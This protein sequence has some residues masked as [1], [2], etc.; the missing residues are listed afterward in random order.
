MELGIFTKEGLNKTVLNSPLTAVGMHFFERHE[1]PGPH[2]IFL[3]EGPVLEGG[4]PL[5]Q[6]L[7]LRPPFGLPEGFAICSGSSTPIEIFQLIPITAHEQHLIV[8]NG[9]DKFE[10][11]VLAQ[12]ID[13]LL[14]NVRQEISF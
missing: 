5:F 7:Y 12:K 8:T 14:F 13:L 11:A 6:S 3:G 2:G 9:W 10:Q 1:S 4:N